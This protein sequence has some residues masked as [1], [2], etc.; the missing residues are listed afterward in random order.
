MDKTILISKLKEIVTPYAKD[1]EGLKNINEHTDFI[2]DLKI[3][4][5]H[6][7]DV[8]LDVEEAFNIEIDND[9]MEQMLNVNSAIDII[10]KKL[11]EKTLKGNER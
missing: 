10:E 1:Q 8:V 5:A 3:N 6:L 11:S 2:K 7:V 9:S 4:S